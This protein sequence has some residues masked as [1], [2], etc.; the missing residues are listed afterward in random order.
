MQ[1]PKL[2][3]TFEWNT[4]IKPTTLVI[5]GWVSLIET[6][7]AETDGG[8]KHIKTITVKVIV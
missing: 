7:E 3:V 8:G 1:T 5:N 6:L 2:E 4:P